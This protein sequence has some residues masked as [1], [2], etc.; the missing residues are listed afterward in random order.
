MKTQ[1]GNHTSNSRVLSALGIAAFIVALP[2]LTTQ[3]QTVLLD[4]NF[5]RGTLGGTYGPPPM[6]NTTG[7]TQLQNIPETPYPGR[8]PLW[9]NNDQVTVVNDLRGLENGRALKFN[10][11]YTGA[12]DAR[13]G[14]DAG[15][16]SSKDGILSI[17]WD[18][19]MDV[20]FDTD[21]DAYEL[22]S[23]NSTPL[24]LMLYGFVGPSATDVLQFNFQAKQVEI[25]GETVNQFLIRGSNS[26]S[27]TNPTNL[28]G[29][30]NY[31]N[32]NT[33]YH[34]ALDLNLNTHLYYVSLYDEDGDLIV[35]N[36]DGF[37]FRD[38]EGIDYFGM[39]QTIRFQAGTAN[40]LDTMGGDGGPIIDNLQASYT[41]PEPNAIPLLLLAGIMA[42]LR[43]HR[44]IC[45][46]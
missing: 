41:I 14:M 3:A 6:T 33:T 27:N 21:N 43:R 38:I 35:R 25:G 2:L 11:K 1:I 42:L 31:I 45:R 7:L 40:F 28:F 5:N 36:I 23:Q 30:N 46:R 12:M 4:E 20:I 34:V 15:P 32:A 26:D 44:A 29:D 19:R 18:F 10:D 17:E 9:I 24:R 39:D 22:F 16:A 13:L 37:Q 8:G